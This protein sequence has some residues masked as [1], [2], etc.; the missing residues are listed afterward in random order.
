MNAGELYH[1]GRPTCR[2][3]FELHSASNCV[4][5]ALRTHSGDRKPIRMIEQMCNTLRIRHTGKWTAGRNPQYGRE[6][7]AAGRHTPGPW[8]WHPGC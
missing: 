2:A 3:V 5:N 7:A 4:Q 1:Y 6:L 8:R